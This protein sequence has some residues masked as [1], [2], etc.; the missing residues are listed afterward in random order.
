[1]APRPP[2]PLTQAQVDF[3]ASGGPLDTALDK[4]FYAGTSPD[5]PDLGAMTSYNDDSIVPDSLRV[6]VRQT[7]KQTI[8][9]MMASSSVAWKTLSLSGGWGALVGYS[10]PRYKINLLNEVQLTGY[11]GNPSLNDPLITTLP[12]GYRPDSKIIVGQVQIDVDGKVTCV[13]N[14]NINVSLDG[15]SFTT[16]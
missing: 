15:V 2:L 13:G 16:P 8:A 1:M 3:L 14:T 12:P 10:V 9:A 11:I 5:V 4:I 6:Q 7:F